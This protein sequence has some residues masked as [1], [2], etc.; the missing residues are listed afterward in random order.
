MFVLEFKFRVNFVLQM[1]HPNVS[2]SIFRGFC[3]HESGII[4]PFRFLFC[5]VL[6]GSILILASTLDI[7]GAERAISGSRSINGEFELPDP[8]TTASRF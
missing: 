1:C 2:P 3:A 5:R 8:N 4:R 7:Q 6:S